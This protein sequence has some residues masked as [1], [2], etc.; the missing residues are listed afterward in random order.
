MAYWAYDFVCDLSLEALAAAASRL[1]P[2]QWEARESY[3]YGDYLNSRPARGVRLRIHMYPQSIQ[4]GEG[5]L[6][7]LRDK[8]YM[9]LLQ[10]DPDESSIA[11]EEIDK[12]FRSLLDKLRATQIT[13]IEPY[14]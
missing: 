2:W 14:D 6:T 7:G 5:T 12:A 3:W 8:G 11:R 10:I 13:E 4:D 9:A 1:G